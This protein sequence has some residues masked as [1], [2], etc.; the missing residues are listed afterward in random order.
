MSP[1]S[2]K[3][4]FAELEFGSKLSL[5]DCLKMEFTMAVRHLMD[6]DFKEGTFWLL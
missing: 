3:V 4:T 5:A 2:M 1:L 6:G